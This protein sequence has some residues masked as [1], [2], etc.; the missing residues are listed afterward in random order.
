MVLFGRERGEHDD[1]GE[2]G[3]SRVT[4]EQAAKKANN[5]VLGSVRAS[6]T[7]TY[8]AAQVRPS[9][10]TQKVTHCSLLNV[11]FSTPA[12]LSRIR[13]TASTRSSGVKNQAVV[14]ESGK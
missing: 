11:L 10:G 7:L 1:Q 5:Q 14:G 2:Y 8:H 6:M 4:Y 13:A 12:W 9:Y 3:R